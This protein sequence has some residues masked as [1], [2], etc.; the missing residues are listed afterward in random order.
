MR[1]VPSLPVL[2]LCIASLLWASS[3]VA[4]KIAFDYYDPL[5]VIFGRM[6][7]AT[8]CFSFFWKNFKNV[9]YQP[10]DW[11]PLVFMAVCEPGLYFVFEALALENT[12]ASQAGMIVAMLPLMM[13]VAAH[14]LLGE[15]IS[16]R[17]LAGFGLAV[18]GAGLLSVG[19]VKTAGAPNPIFGNCM[20]LLAMVCA[21]GYMITLKRLCARYSPWFLT[22]VQAV[23]GSL[24]FLPLQFL[25]TT[26]APTGFHATGLWA[27]IYLGAVISIG[28]YGLYNYGT[29]KIP[30][31][32]ASAFTNLIPVLTL[33]MGWL[34]LGETLTWLQYVASVI[35]LLGVVLSQGRKSK[36][37]S[38]NGCKN[39]Q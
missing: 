29:S 6:A 23:V 28:A 14:F 33:G 4:L 11:K 24:F 38:A 19:A 20:E 13:A 17:T 37:K 5:V 2:A 15:I 32:Q 25:P 31:H 8:L 10:G 21:T 34:I 1:S 9:N 30:A 12:Q 18:V 3:F 27:I 22:A 35:V 16:R 36:K 26:A 39:R 7:V